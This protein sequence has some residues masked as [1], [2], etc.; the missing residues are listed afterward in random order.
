MKKNKNNKRDKQRDK[1]DDYSFAKN[2]LPSFPNE[3]VIQDAVKDFVKIT[4]KEIDDFP[5]SE[6]KKGILS[7]ARDDILKEIQQEIHQEILD[8]VSEEIEKSMN[9]IKSELTCDIKSYIL[10]DIDEY[11]DTKLR[12]LGI[13]P[14]YPIDKMSDKEFYDGIRTAVDSG[15]ITDTSDDYENDGTQ[16]VKDS[17]DND[18]TPEIK[19]SAEV[20]KVQD[21]TS[22]TNCQYKQITETDDEGNPIETIDGEHDEIFNPCN[23]CQ[24]LYECSCVYGRDFDFYNCYKCKLASICP[25]VNSILDAD[26]RTSVK[27]E[28]KTIVDNELFEYGWHL[29]FVHRDKEDKISY[30][31]YSKADCDENY[32]SVKHV[33]L[34]LDKTKDKKGYKASM[35]LAEEGYSSFYNENEV[36][37][38]TN[39]TN[40]DIN[41]IPFNELVL[42]IRK[43]NELGA[44]DSRWN[45]ALGE[46]DIKKE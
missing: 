41:S 40:S 34:C 36:E 10:S 11:I 15:N 1:Q 23:N 3:V 27:E 25:F 30:L 31:T 21:Y 24:K 14:T 5:A 43:I 44:T 33:V 17:R 7:G 12:R 19:E 39:Y 32:H 28:D 45:E 42:F 8:T 2:V 20:H 16:D 26:Y 9:L 6:S 22:C 4:D 46:L 38:Y 18:V 35:T 29:V 37:T 13:D